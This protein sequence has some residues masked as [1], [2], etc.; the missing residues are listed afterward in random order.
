VGEPGDPLERFEREVERLSAEVAELRARVQR[1]EPKATREVRE[2]QFGLTAVNRIGALT[3][4]IGIIFFF[5]YAVDNQWIGARGRTLLGAAGGLLLIGAGEWLRARGQRVFA[6]GI[7]G[8]GLAILYIT[9]Y[10]AFAWYRLLGQSAA[11]ACLIVISALAI[12]LSLRYAHSAIAALGFT[13]GLLTPIL[14]S[15][16][17]SPA[18]ITL[19]YLFLL[20]ATCVLIVYKRGWLTLAPL[21][22]AE[23]IAAALFLTHGADADRFAVLCLAVAAVHFVAAASVRASQRVRDALYATGHGFMAAGLLRE[24]DLEVRRTV[25]ESGRSAA[26]SEFGSL[27]LAAYG[28]AALAWGI[29]RDSRMTRTIGLVLIGIV[30][31]KLYL[32]DVWFLERLYR[33]SAFGGLGILLLAASWIYSRSK[34]A[35][36]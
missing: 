34:D 2:T 19:A 24:V 5:K 22:G 13:G 14:L 23:T 29:A 7:A 18:A 35:R 32:W 21:I 11:A 30:I 17:P 6:Q 8:C 31:A 27:F 12:G 20:D 10:A 9:C 15:S 36:G 16:E 28:I 3:L 25:A 4:A 26:E 33:M 1:L